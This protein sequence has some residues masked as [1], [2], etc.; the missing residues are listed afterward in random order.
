MRK[1]FALVFNA[2][3]GLARPRLLDG[4]LVVL[5]DAGADVFQVPARS[6]E[7]ASMRVAALAGQRG[8]DAVIAAGGDG[9]F[10]AVAT[11]AADT[12]LPVGF[13][14]LGT[15]NILA[16][17][18]G[19]R[20]RAAELARGLLENPAIPVRGG[21]V[22][23]AAFFLM[24][25][26]GFDAAIVH[27]LNYKTK[28]LIARAAYTSP[29][30]KTILRGS[31]MFD[32][33]VDGRAFEASWVIVTRASHYG[34]SFV[35]TRETQLG[36]SGMIAVVFESQSRAAL[37]VAATALGLGRLVNPATRPRGVTV[38]QAS[39]VLIGKNTKVPVQ[40]DGDESGTT[41][42]DILAAGPV[43][44]VIVPVSYVAELTNRHTNHVPSVV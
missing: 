27:G 1:K 6:A 21:L 43:V 44:R 9:T 2:R 36:A 15:G 4:V 25:G 12:E 14:P 8:A 18:I 16:Y 37:L 29:F 41:P 38:L 34:G 19:I 11:G 17:E 22:N 7:E 13:I 35:L 20:K 31:D 10:R 30:V 3:A 42:V 5:K 28:R 40:V 23:G 32:V 39:R 24:V 33:E 26:A